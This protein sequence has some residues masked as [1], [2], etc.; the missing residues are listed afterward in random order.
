M[1]RSI[2]RVVAGKDAQ[3]SPCSIPL[4]LPATCHQLHPCSAFLPF[5]MHYLFRALLPH[6]RRGADVE[7]PEQAGTQT[8]SSSVLRRTF[9]AAISPASLLRPCFGA[10]H[11]AQAGSQCILK[12]LSPA[13]LQAKHLAEAA[14]NPL[15]VLPMS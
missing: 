10:A 13:K 4:V 2:R 12:G 8:E 7:I 11:S 6:A 5:S 15:A 14:T 3:C 9:V 1:P